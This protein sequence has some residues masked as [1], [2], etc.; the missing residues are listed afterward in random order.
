MAFIVR[1][2]LR[3]LSSVT[4]IVSHMMVPAALIA[5]DSLIS[6]EFLLCSL[7]MEKEN[8]VTFT[9]FKKSIKFIGVAWLIKSRSFQVCASIILHLYTALCVHHSKLPSVTIYR[10]RQS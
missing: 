1:M 2:L 5:V 6:P 4:L 7:Y 10:V 9:F 8:P 3:I